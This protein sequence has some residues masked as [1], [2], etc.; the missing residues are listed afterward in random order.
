MEIRKN[1]SMFREYV[2]TKYKYAQI[3]SNQISKFSE[4][5]YR[6]QA[7]AI[8]SDLSHDYRKDQYLYIPINLWRAI[9]EAYTDYT[10]WMWFNVDFSWNEKANKVFTDISDKIWLQKI[11]NSAVDN[12][13]SIWYCILRCRKRDWDKLPRV[14]IIPVS[15]Y[16]ANMEWLS[17]WD[18]FED[19]KEHFVY[20]VVKNSYDNTKYF[21]V[22][23]Y[24]KVGD[25]WVWHYWEKWKYTVDF[26][27]NEKL[28]E[29]VEEPLEE[30]PLFL[31]NNDLTDIH[32]VEED[33]MP[34][35]NVKKAID[36]W[37]I[38]RY[39]NQSDY[40]DLWDLFQ[41]MN[42]RVSQISVEYIKNLTSK[43]SV[44]ASFSQDLK[45]KALKSKDKWFTEN[46]D[47]ITHN[48][49]ET[50]AQ[51]IMK[52]W[53]YIQ[54][55]INDYIPL[56]L[57]MVSVVSKVPASI[58]WASL[59]AWGQNPVGTTEKEWWMFYSRI[60]KKQLEL[61]NPLQKL[62]RM[63]IKLQWITVEELPTIK[64]KKP[65]A[66]DVWERTDIAIAQMNA[67]IM[68]KESAIAFTM[69]Y[70]DQEVTEE[71]E[72]IDDETVNAYKRDRSLINSNLDDNNTEEDESTTE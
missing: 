30:L 9:T 38:P 51:Y 67:W 3:F 29:W 28:E 11:L 25:W 21:Y 53:W 36:F 12:Q 17:I 47:Y 50:P 70:D 32:V 2:K 33:D 34:Y 42:D 40:V 22:D 37:D 72:K 18:W 69:W 55:S 35:T 26:I 20:S 56:L 62:F 52:D 71:L 48:V 24:E 54:T 16:V 4:K 6:K 64:F 59:Y 15:N 44:P 14:E 63:L 19:I 65:T 27:L 58:L 43:L 5:D 68:S 1:L 45:A 49:W 13:S 41:E 7:F 60:D 10:I 61:Y 23:R 66:Y 39:F 57:K 31:L 8:K 46:P